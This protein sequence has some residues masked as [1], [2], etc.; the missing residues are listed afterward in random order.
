MVNTKKIRA[1]KKLMIFAI[2]VL[3]VTML[4]A[5]T[6][7]MRSDDM[8]IKFAE[9]PTEAQQFVGKYFGKE[10]VSHVMKDAEFHGTDYKVVFVSGSKV[11]F[12]TN[13]NWTEIDCRYS[14]VP[15][16]IVPDKIESYIKDS[17]AANKVVEIKRERNEWEVKLTGG[18]ELTFNKDFQLIDIDD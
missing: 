7:I 17:Y 11:E 13:G 14:T 15:N 6:S 9:L 8:P 1:M 10:E 2:G 5:A 12:D 4:S 16:A 3:S 18:L